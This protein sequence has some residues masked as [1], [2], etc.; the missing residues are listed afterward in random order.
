MSQQM[1]CHELLTNLPSD[2]SDTSDMRIVLGLVLL[3]CRLHN[4]PLC[5]GSVLREDFCACM[6]KT[7]I[8]IQPFVSLPFRS[9]WTC[10]VT[11]ALTFM[12][13]LAAIQLKILALIMFGK[14]LAVLLNTG[15]FNV[16]DKNSV[17]HLWAFI[18]YS[19][20]II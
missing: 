18:I 16:G 14:S 11:L 10:L 17:R 19:K 4:N 13:C 3:L 15:Q 2:T 8:R 6:F 7:I 1:L 9:I 12:H 20:T 5:R